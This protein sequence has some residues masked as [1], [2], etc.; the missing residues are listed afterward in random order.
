MAQKVTAKITTIS[1]RIVYI[2]PE[3]FTS[4]GVPENPKAVLGSL[5]RGSRSAL[6]EVYENED[7]TG[8][9]N[10]LNPHFIELVSLIYNN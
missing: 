3:E 5:I 2:G 8:E 7:L 9:K 10:F 1:G 4:M 6:V